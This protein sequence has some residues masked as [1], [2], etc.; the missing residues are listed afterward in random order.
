MDV[1]HE[2]YFSSLKIIQSFMKEIRQTFIEGNN[3]PPSVGSLVM[4]YNVLISKATK[5][6]I[7]VVAMPFIGSNLAMLFAIYK[8]RV[9]ASIMFFSGIILAFLM[10]WHYKKRTVEQIIIQMSSNDLVIKSDEIV[11]IPFNDII[12]YNVQLIEE[13]RLELTVKGRR[14]IKLTA[15]PKMCDTIPLKNFISDFETKMTEFELNNG[16]QAKKSKT[17]WETKYSLL[18]LIPLSIG[19]VVLFLM[20]LLKPDNASKALPHVILSLSSLILL[21]SYYLTKRQR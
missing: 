2:H 13:V 15:A 3:K 18:I 7:M 4:E 1:E 14:K 6:I 8:E 21:W 9:L 10:Y 17:F 19:V 11:I 16:L 20:M 12:N 5:L